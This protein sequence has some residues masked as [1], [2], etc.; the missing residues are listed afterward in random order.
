MPTVAVI[1]LK[2]NMIA[3]FQLADHL[4]FVDI[5]VLGVY[6]GDVGE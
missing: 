2:L 5:V 1:Y 6:E 4:F 3:S